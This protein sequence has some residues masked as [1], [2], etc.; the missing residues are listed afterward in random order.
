L[1]AI[2]GLGLTFHNWASLVVYVVCGTAGVLYRIRVEERVLLTELGA[3]YADYA[4]TT[5]RLVP[6]VW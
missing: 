6:H 4:A 3:A 1:V 5:S 2:V